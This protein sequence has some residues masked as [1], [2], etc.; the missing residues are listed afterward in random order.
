MVLILNYKYMKLK[1]S[2]VVVAIV[3]V[4]LLCGS[5]LYIKNYSKSNFY[6]QKD[7]GL[8]IPYLSGWSSYDLT[9]DKWLNYDVPSGWFKNLFS[10]ENVDTVS[11]KRRVVG[12]VNT[13]KVKG[14]E[15]LVFNN[16]KNIKYNDVHVEVVENT[17]N[18]SL[19]KFVKAF[20]SKSYAVYKNNEYCSDVPVKV[21][22]GATL[23]ELSKT[24]VSSD[25]KIG[26]ILN[27]NI[28]YPAFIKD[29]SG[30]LIY[31][32]DTINIPIMSCLCNLYFDPNLISDIA[33]G[34]SIWSPSRIVENKHGFN[35]IYLNSGTQQSICFPKSDESELSIL[36]TIS[37][38][39]R[40]SLAEAKKIIE[41]S[42]LYVP[43]TSYNYMN[44]LAEGQVTE[45][46]FVEV[47]R[48]GNHSLIVVI[49]PSATA[50]WSIKQMMEYIAKN[51]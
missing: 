17:E 41:S 6:L 48:E 16:L 1:F 18:L 28:Y 39:Q 49:Y 19:V 15:D 47:P 5:V 35:A 11:K 32:G 27:N 29:H 3:F 42:T 25:V 13:G 21:Y 4:V 26:D 34:D 24:F 30:D 20:L 9:V 44:L 7:Y 8:K 45:F 23:S 36:E 37:N 51:I 14:T 43:E 12:F 31:E 38:D 22:K 46:Y 33:S 40:I 10:K 2:P 50:D